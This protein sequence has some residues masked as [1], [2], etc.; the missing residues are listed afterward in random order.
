MAQQHKYILSSDE[1]TKFKKAFDDFD[2]MGQ[3]RIPT[4]RLGD[5]MRNLGV[6][7][8][9]REL[10]KLIRAVDVNTDGSVELQEFLELM[11]V[12]I[13]DDNI[14][15][16]ELRLIMT[17]IGERVETPEIEAMIAEA[18]VDGDGAV[19]YWEFV[20][21]MLDD[22]RPA[23]EKRKAARTRRGRTTGSGGR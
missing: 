19:D 12:K 4:S 1:E 14:T 20:N 13:Q 6:H 22:A 21:M 11:S 18:D 9:E 3:G 17:V 15:P 23:T 5:M 10:Q 8:E 7:T 16:E 2:Y